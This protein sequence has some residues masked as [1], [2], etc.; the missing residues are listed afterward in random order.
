MRIAVR[1]CVEFRRVED[2]VGRVRQL[3]RADLFVAIV[4]TFTDAT[5]GSCRVRANC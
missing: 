3:E 2:G 5:H 4:V 1:C